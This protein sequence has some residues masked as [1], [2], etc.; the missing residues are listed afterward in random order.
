MGLWWVMDREFVDRGSYSRVT[1]SLS[2]V[3]LG[4]GGGGRWWFGLQK[5]LGK[6]IDQATGANQDLD[7]EGLAV[8]APIPSGLASAV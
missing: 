3:A 6:E 1:A 2:R 7:R 5:D 8:V 4:C